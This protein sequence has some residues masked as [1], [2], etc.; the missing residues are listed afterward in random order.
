MIRKIFLGLLI[1]LIVLQFFHPTRNRSDAAQTAYIGNTYAVPA[2]V[3]TILQKACNDCHSNNTDYPWYSYVQPVDWWL[4]NHIV[5]GKRGL[6]FDEFTNRRP[7]SQYHKLEELI[8]QVKEGKMPLNSY[9]WIHKNAILTIAEKD[10]LETW[11]TAIRTQME[12]IYPP[13]SLTRKKSP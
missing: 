3:K 12:A 9:T 2:S 6:N 13:D 8:D 1:I 5:D 4:N 7:R 11:A 10:S